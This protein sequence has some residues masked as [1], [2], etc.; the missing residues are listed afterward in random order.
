MEKLLYN[1]KTAFS[2]K[3]II[4]LLVLNLLDLVLTYLGL[5]LKYFIEGNPILKNIYTKSESSFLLVK[6][7]VT[8]F[9]C[10][11]IGRGLIKFKWVRKAIFIPL[12]VYIIVLIMH[13]HVLK[14]YGHN[15]CSIFTNET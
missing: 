11:F 4:A 13:I 1:I 7:S 9:S 3:T 14:C 12:V 8:L 10:Y 5:K 15:I 2:Q 6:I